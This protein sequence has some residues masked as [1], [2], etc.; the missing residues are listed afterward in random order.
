MSSL[1]S[2]YRSTDCRLIN[3]LRQMSVWFKSWA[4]KDF[5]SESRVSSPPFKHYPHAHNRD[6]LT[7]WMPLKFNCRDATKRELNLALPEE[8]F[9]H[10]RK[11]WKPTGKKSRITLSS[12][13]KYFHTVQIDTETYLAYLRKVF[14]QK[15][16][17]KL[18]QVMII[19]GNFDG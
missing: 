2:V 6:Y 13:G 15:G 8:K 19:E 11:Y 7:P 3:D 17:R 18:L 10:G 5:N 16:E 12:A 1:C 4:V 14:V 9:K